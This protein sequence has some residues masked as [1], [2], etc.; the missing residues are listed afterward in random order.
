MTPENRGF[1]L[2]FISHL[3]EDSV[4]CL[5]G[6]VKN[7]WKSKSCPNCRE[8]CGF[9]HPG[10]LCST[11][12]T[13]RVSQCPPP[14]QRPPGYFSCLLPLRLLAE[15]RSRERDH[16]FSKWPRPH[17][18]AWPNQWF[19]YRA[20][21][22]ESASDIRPTKQTNREPESGIRDCHQRSHLPSST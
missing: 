4:K 13:Q 8:D 12:R 17:A 11:Q 2:I 20:C 6:Q 1:V 15:G 22:S 14:N 9:C 3:R 5:E 16:E 21:H 18:L 19:N 7:S 10:Q